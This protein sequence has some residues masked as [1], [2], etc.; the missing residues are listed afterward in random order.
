MSTRQVT[1]NNRG[2]SLLNSLINNLSTEIHIPGYQFAGPGTKLAKR[3]A[4]GQT[5]INKLDSLCLK[6]DIAYDGDKN[7]EKRRVAD[8]ILEDASWELVKSKDTGIKEE[9][10]SWLVCNA[11]KVKCKLGM[12][13]SFKDLVKAAKKNY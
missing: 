2:G 7:L 13:C 4:L 9:A 11:M 6:H 1:K 5:G 12:G 3:L 8:K 10:A